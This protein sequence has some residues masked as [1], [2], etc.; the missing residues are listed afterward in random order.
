M[1]LDCDV[2]APSD[3]HRATVIWLHGIGQAPGV[4][5]DLVRRLGLQAFGVRNVFPRAPEQH[6]S[7]FTGDTVPAWF[8][9]KIADL[10]QADLKELH[11]SERKLHALVA[12]ESQRI[13]AD[14]IFLAGFSQG[15]ALALIAGLRYPERLGGLVLYAPYMLK[16]V[17]LAGSRS[18]SNLA[19]PIWIGHGRQDFVVS[20]RQGGWV[21]NALRKWGYTVFWHMYEGAHE[22]FGGAVDDVRRFFIEYIP[23]SSDRNDLIDVN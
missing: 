4:F 3:E 10:K 21:R 7:M 5:A 2:I 16:K 11:A 18:P 12:A 13:G 17:G 9:Q 6:V 8:E 15:A 14:R 20:V 1:T 22:T 23:Q 19:V